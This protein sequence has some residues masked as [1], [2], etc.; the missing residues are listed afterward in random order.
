M[1]ILLPLVLVGISTACS[2][3]Y[4]CCVR[5][6]FNTNYRAKVIATHAFAIEGFQIF[7]ALVAIISSWNSFQSPFLLRDRHMSEIKL[8]L[9]NWLTAAAVLATHLLGILAI[10]AIDNLVQ[11]GTC[12]HPFQ[13]QAFLLTRSVLLPQTIRRRP[14]VTIKTSKKVV[15]EARGRSRTTKTLT[16]SVTPRRASSQPATLLRLRDM[17]VELP[18]ETRNAL[19]RANTFG[20][21]RDMVRFRA[22]TISTPTHAPKA[23]NM[24]HDCSPLRIKTIEHATQALAVVESDSSKTEPV[25]ATSPKSELN[26]PIQNTGQSSSLGSEDIISPISAN[27]RRLE[28]PMTPESLVD[29]VW[30][31]DHSSAD[32]LGNSC[33][34]RPR[35]RAFSTELDG[36]R[37]GMS[38]DSD[39]SVAIRNGRA[40]GNSVKEKVQHFEQG[41]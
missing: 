24:M 41:L 4:N 9:A 33:I 2:M 12:N 8:H 7:L 18:S 14:L 19:A 27:E 38:L 35:P 39:G 21:R 30:T 32:R 28:T 15:Q 6:Y 22:R 3:A 16:S 5:L 40:R 29:E 37:K 36:M 10:E 13:M 26:L 31:I 23:A 34:L 20:K 17:G 25:E 1:T 11:I